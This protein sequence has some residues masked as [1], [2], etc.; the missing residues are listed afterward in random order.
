MKHT[1]FTVASFTLLAQSVGSCKT[2]PK[3]VTEEKVIVAR[4]N[5]KE[6]KKAA[7]AEEW[8]EFKEKTDAIIAQNKIQLIELRTKMHKAKESVDSDYEEDV[9]ELE[10]KNNE[11][12]ATLEQYKNDSNSDWESFKIEF[13][14]DADELGLAIKDF[15]IN[16]TNN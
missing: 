16:N 11:L 10:R 2:E 5:L 15:T 9:A 8:K 1:L 3:T 7:S 4:E 14:H 6:A 13:N 12:K